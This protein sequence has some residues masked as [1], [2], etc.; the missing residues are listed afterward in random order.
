LVLVIALGVL[1]KGVFLA[2]SLPSSSAWVSE[3][4]FLPASLEA[5]A[6]Y[7][8]H[9]PVS[10]S[11]EMRVSVC[12]LASV[13]FVFSSF[14][15]PKSILRTLATNRFNSSLSVRPFFPSVSLRF[16]SLLY[17]ARLTSLSLSPQKGSQ[18]YPACVYDGHWLY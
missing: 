5:S 4:W 3:S 16:S 6:P 12:T 10:F 15:P 2:L 17:S 13:F 8:K 11:H 14:S 9:L 18:S 7:W 1:V